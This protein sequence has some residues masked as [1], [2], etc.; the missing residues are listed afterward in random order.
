MNWSHDSLAGDLAGHLVAPDRMVWTNMQ[1]GPVGSPR[2]D[3]YTIAKSYLHPNPTAYEVKVSMS[4]FRADATAGKWSAYLTYASSVIFACP[5][6]LISKTELP[7]QCGLIV[8]HETV[9][10]LAKRATVNP[11]VIDQAALLKL[12]IDGVH[13]EGP[14]MRAKQWHN[15]DMVREFTKRFGA[16]AARYVADAASVHSSI[17]AAEEHRR[18]ILYRAETEAA[19]IRKRAETDAPR[20]WAEL[21]A[22]LGL[23]AN[24]NRF[25]VER[26]LRALRTESAGGREVFALRDALNSLQR[27]INTYA[28][29]LEE[30]SRKV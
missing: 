9:W 5:A 17:A 14:K 27:I 1:L 4:D 19:E 8:R 13:R 21:L 28:W 25:D 12:I 30:Q 24:S 29:A 7:H 15:G 2:P 26:E 16:A 11:V 18:Q 22:V 10:R 3:V 20:L 6:G 23:G